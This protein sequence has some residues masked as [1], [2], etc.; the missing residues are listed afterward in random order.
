[1]IS[2]A[3]SELKQSGWLE[4]KLDPNDARKRVYKLK[5][6]EQVVKEMEKRI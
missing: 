5:S 1:M 4:M 2:I 6:P 3:L